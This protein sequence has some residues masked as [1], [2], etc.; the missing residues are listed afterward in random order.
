MKFLFV[1]L[2]VLVDSEIPFKVSLPQFDSQKWDETSQTGLLCSG[3][4]FLIILSIYH[5]SSSLKKG[6]KL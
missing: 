1:I 3:F 6:L 4:V 2:K 5:S